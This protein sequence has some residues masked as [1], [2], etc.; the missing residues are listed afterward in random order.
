MLTIAVFWSAVKPE[1]RKWVSGGTGAQVVTR[2]FE[3]RIGYL[4]DA[5]ARFDGQQVSKG[6]Q[7]LVD[8]L[9]YVDFIAATLVRVPDVIPHQEGRQISQAVLHILTPRFLFPNKPP[10][11]ND[12][13][14]T[15][16]YTGLRTDHDV[17]ASIS[18]GYM[19][20]FYIDFGIP[21]V[22]LGPLFMGLACGFARKWIHQRRAVPIAARYGLALII[23][24]PL[25]TFET[26]LIKIVGAVMMGLAASIA[27]AWALENVG[28]RGLFGPLRRR[29]VRHEPSGAA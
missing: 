3:E 15:A 13:V 4:A 17:N 12:S 7:A 5:A 28:G 27:Y 25:S 24:M 9:S 16:Y 14:V 29:P 8:R 11:P 18:I 6:V 1:Y 10:T 2:P 22:F 23:A 21:G 20:E 26:A 19:G